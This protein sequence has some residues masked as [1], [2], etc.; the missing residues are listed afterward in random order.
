MYIQTYI[1]DMCVSQ[2]CL[3]FSKTA[4]EIRSTCEERT[5]SLQSGNNLNIQYCFVM[6]LCICVQCILCT[7]YYINCV[8]KL[9]RN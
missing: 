1:H 5:N 7:V 2:T 9:Y 8:V 3:M 6:W 4:E